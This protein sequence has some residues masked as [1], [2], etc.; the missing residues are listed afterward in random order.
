[1]RTPSAAMSMDSLPAN[2]SRSVASIPLLSKPLASGGANPHSEIG[3]GSKHTLC[4][5]FR[6]LQEGVP[7]SA[8]FSIFDSPDSVTMELLRSLRALLLMELSAR[9]SNGVAR[10]V[11]RSVR[12]PEDSALGTPNSLCGE[13]QLCECCCLTALGVQLTGTIRAADGC[14]QVLENSRDDCRRDDSQ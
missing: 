3:P 12:E 9:L 2:E 4:L 7:L 6:A 8:E 5:A 1:M 14:R 10:D 11:E 13:N